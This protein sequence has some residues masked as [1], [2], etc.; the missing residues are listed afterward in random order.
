MRN[1]FGKNEELDRIKEALTV[2]ECD[3]SVFRNWQKRYDK[4]NRQWMAVQDQY[5]KARLATR[6]VEADTRNLEKMLNGEE[7]EDRKEF[8]RLLKNLKQQKNGFDHEF[9]ISREDHE[10]HS[11]YDTILKLG[12]KALDNAADRLILQSEIE[13]LLALLRENLEKSAPDPRH[14]C[15]YYQ[16]GTDQELSKLPPAE[17]LH[18]IDRVYEHE[19][20]KPLMEIVQQAIKRADE[21]RTHLQG[22]TDRRSCKVLDAIAVLPEDKNGQISVR[23]RARHTIA[24]LIG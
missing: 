6:Q 7:A 20:V 15:Y 12:V 23:E 24:P 21:Q 22:K 19:F 10:F 18:K 17:R 13:N 9:L 11:T 16:Q 3:M 4:V 8:I 5:E 1:M 14:L 2:M